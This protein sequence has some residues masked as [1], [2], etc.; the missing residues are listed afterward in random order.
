MTG[1]EEERE[2]KRETGK[3][4]KR[5]ER[6]T[7][8]EVWRYP[9]GVHGGGEEKTRGEGMEMLEERLQSKG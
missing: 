3:K 9:Y 6:G 1:E 7:R 4:G 8:I 5:G 2:R